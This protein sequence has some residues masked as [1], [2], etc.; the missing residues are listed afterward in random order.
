MQTPAS[1][2]AENLQENTTIPAE[3]FVSVTPNFPL[4]TNQIDDSDS[5]VQTDEAEDEQDWFR[6]E[7][8]D[9]MKE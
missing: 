5:N 3:V 6:P 4:G 2:P 9:E 7:V 1:R 8:E